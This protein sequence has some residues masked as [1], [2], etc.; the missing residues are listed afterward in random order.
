MKKKSVSLLCIVLSLIILQVNVKFTNA[1]EGVNLFDEI[2]IV[3]KSKTV[4][5]GLKTSF[6]TEV[7][8]KEIVNYLIESLDL[9]NKDIKLVRSEDGYSYC[10]EFSGVNIEGYIEGLKSNN[11]ALKNGKKNNITINI[12]KKMNENGLEALK[13]KVINS[14][15]SH[16]K[17][18]KCFQYLKAKIDDSSSLAVNYINGAII[19]ILKSRGAK[20]IDTVSINNGLSTIAYTQKYNEELINNKLIDFNY[21][22]CNYSS[23][24]YIII[25]TPEIIITY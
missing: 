24:R 11:E 20:N 10:I 7:N 25:G 18:I 19:K 22:I 23:G 9:N 5:Y 15:G 6:N 16:G 4:E 2:L 13:N 1:Q 12:S 17:D 8:P 21:A 14:I 3:S